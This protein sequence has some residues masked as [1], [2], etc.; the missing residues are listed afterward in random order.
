MRI[1]I[2]ALLC[3]ALA[4]PAVAQQ[5]PEFPKG[6]S[7]IVQ[8]TGSQAASGFGNYLVPPLT[9][10][11]RKAGLRYRGD[12]GVE[13]AATVETGSDVGK[14][15][16]SGAGRAWLYTRFVTVGLSPADIDIEP[17]GRLTPSFWVKVQLVTPNE[18]RVDEL[19]CLI[20]LATRE[21]AARYR[22]EGGVTVDGQGCARK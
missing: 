21:L 19:N 5:S 2:I 17:E 11:M 10:A 15:Q 9:Q 22:P 13:F 3:L 14:W 16:G 20:A 7:Y 8:L 6:R 12:A 1:R 18:D 4:G